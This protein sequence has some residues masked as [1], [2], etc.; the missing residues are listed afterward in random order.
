MN[1]KYDGISLQNRR[2]CNMDS[3]YLAG[4]VLQS[5][6]L[7]IAVVCDGVGG[8]PDGA[9]AASSAT[10]MLRYW[11]ENLEALS[12]LGLR[13]RDYV[14]A[15]NQAIFKRAKMR[16]MQTAT[17]L[18]CLLL[19]QD[20]YCIVH[21]GD[22]RIYSWLNSYLQLLTHDHVSDGCLTQSIGYSA[23]TELYYREGIS[24]RGQKFLLCS[25]G[26]YKKMRFSLL[27]N[28]MAGLTGENVGNA[29]RQLAD[30]VIERGEN[31]N[32]SIALFVSKEH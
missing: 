4:R 28:V 20:Q 16:G 5:T 8:L 22:S 13:L 32:I 26:L 1:W 30:H 7:C 12:G 2:N 18:S 17:T 23:E 9:F 25:D 14:L 6:E 29:M 31:D 27:N 24:M 11:F 21:A 10:A 19:W 15:V 3:L